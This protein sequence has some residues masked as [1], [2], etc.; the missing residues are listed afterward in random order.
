MPILI[1]Q[2][3]DGS[4]IEFDKGLFDDWC[5]YLTRRGGEKYAPRDEQYFDELKKY[6]CKY[7]KERIWTDFVKIYDVTSSEIDE[8][9][10]DR[11]S[12]IAS[13]YGEDSINIDVW[14]TVIYA[15][16]VAEENKKY[17]KLKKRIKRLGMYQLLVDNETPSFAANFSKGMKWQE[18][19]MIMRSKGF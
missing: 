10:L 7:S 14:F 5:V 1:K 12:E 3:S 16:M 11:I 18:L 13:S 15:G 17:A 19:D 2:F 9:V 8:E 6:C 4:F